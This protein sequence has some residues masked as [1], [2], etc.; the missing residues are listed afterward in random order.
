MSRIEWDQTWSVGDDQLDK[1]HKTLVA[2]INR[3]ADSE[4]Q[5]G[6]DPQVWRECFSEMVLYAENHFRHEEER[7][8]QVGFPELESHRAGHMRFRKQLSILA[9]EAE[10]APRGALPDLHSFLAGWF[11][12]HILKEDQRY[13]PYVEAKVAKV[14]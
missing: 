13:K 1:E 3:L 11:K 6:L 5:H 7:M 12:E 2:L 8:G 9:S 4:V 14:R 10:V